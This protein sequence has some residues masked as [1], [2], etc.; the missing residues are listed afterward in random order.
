M[1]LTVDHDSFDP[2]SLTFANPAARTGPTVDGAAAVE[3]LQREG[4]S[5]AESFTLQHVCDAV[6]KHRRPMS[7]TRVNFRPGLSGEADSE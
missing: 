2:G 7:L 3:W 4:R 1:S 5:T 6:H